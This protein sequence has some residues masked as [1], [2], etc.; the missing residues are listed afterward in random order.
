MFVPLSIATRALTVALFLAPT[1]IQ[2]ESVSAPQAP[3]PLST[4]NASS[5]DCSTTLSHAEAREFLRA[6]MR[7]QQRIRLDL[8]RM[9]RLAI[10]A[11][12]EPHAVGFLSQANAVLQ[13]LL[14][15]IDV[16]AN[17]AQFGSMHIANGSM[18]WVCI[19]LTPTDASG[20]RLS[21]LDCTLSTQGLDAITLET[22]AFANL[23]ISD[24]DMAIA[25][26]DW[27]SRWLGMVIE[28]LDG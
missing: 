13:R 28:L 15:D 23:A 9:R 5:S 22:S 7:V 17:S 18:T 24:I 3:K 11:A 12:N 4:T 16:I 19:Q 20:M 2:H 25:I 26:S 1:S 14:H 21:M 6:L 27:R 8:E 10:V